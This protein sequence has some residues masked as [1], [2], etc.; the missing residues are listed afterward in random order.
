MSIDVVVGNSHYVGGVFAAD[1][2]SVVEVVEKVGRPVVVVVYAILV[3][4]VVGRVFFRHQCSY[5]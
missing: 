1:G 3:G 2:C 4:F 5:D